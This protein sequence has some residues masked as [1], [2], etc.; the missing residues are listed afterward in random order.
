[1]KNRV[2]KILFAITA[3]CFINHLNA[4]SEDKS[5]TYK[6]KEESLMKFIEQYE[7]RLIPLYVKTAKSSYEARISGKEKDFKRS[8]KLQ[9]KL[10][11][12][13]SNKDDFKKLESFKSSGKITD[14]NLKRQLD[15]IYNLYESKQIDPAKLKEIIELQSSIE[16]KFSTFRSKIDDK[17]LTDNQIEEILKTSLSS[18]ELES[19]WLASKKI[20]PVVSDDVIKLVKLRNA[21]AKELGFKN[22]HQMSLKLDEQDP[23]EIEKLFNELDVATRPAFIRLKRKIDTVLAKRYGVHINKLMPWHY[24]NRFFQEAPKIYS[25]D[26]DKYYQDKDLVAITG[27][28]YKSIGLPIN[29]IIKNSD[30]YEKPNKYQHACCDNIDRKK[31][32]RVICNIKP[33]SY[34]MDTM[35]HEY[36]HA[37]YEKWIDQ[38]MPWTFREPSHT[39]TTEA[40]AMLFGRMSTNPQWLHDMVDIS[41]EE[42]EKIS[43]T[44]FDIMRLKQLVFSRWSQVMYRFEK[45]MYEKPD[46]DLNKLWWR[47]VSKYQMIK[48]PKLR[49]LPDWST[50]IHVAL[51]PAYYHNYLM[52]ELLASQLHYYMVKNIIKSKDFKNQSY[53]G[54]EEVG[55]FLIDNVFMPGRKY[56][57]NDMIKKATGK[58]LTPSYYARQFIK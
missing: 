36:G 16:Q 31:D 42:Q 9:V 12:L 6:Q 58:K 19:A 50:K 21:A 38:T 10:S 18:E 15:L 35:L 41:K 7:S 30:L 48:K 39:F 55:K 13:Y 25:I 8:A 51:Y 24:Q 11:N 47:L 57:W 46:Q 28:Y 32:I 1:M 33:N 29:D 5:Q 54:N 40:I 14:P 37:A 56:Y 52:G 43:Q 34:W 3:V 53:A 22:Y 2:I 27:N 17:E 49:N 45:A 23:R 4:K 26:L 20:G 44:S